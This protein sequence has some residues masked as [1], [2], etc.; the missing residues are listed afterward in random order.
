MHHR[1]SN[2]NSWRSPIPLAQPVGGC[3]MH[4]GEP[5]DRNEMPC[6]EPS[7]FHLYDRKSEIRHR[8]NGNSSRPPAPK[9]YTTHIPQISIK[10]Q[11]LRALQDTRQLSLSSPP[12][13]PPHNVSQT[14]PHSSHQFLLS[15]FSRSKVLPWQISWNRVT[16]CRLPA[17]RP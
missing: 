1:S 2:R 10:N 16:R 13:P 8:K 3:A 4:A 6:V 14:P 11:L 17:Y 9:K 5:N 7:A 12:P 15:V